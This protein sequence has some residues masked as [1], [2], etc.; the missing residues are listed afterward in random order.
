MSARKILLHGGG[1]FSVKEQSIKDALRG[2]SSLL[3]IP[4]ARPGGSAC[5]EVTEDVR[6]GFGNAGLTIKINGIE[7]YRNPRKAVEDA[8]AVFVGGGN[9]FVLLKSLYDERL[10]EIMRAGVKEGMPY[11]GASAGANVAGQTIKTTNDMP[12]VYPPSFNAIGL[13]PFVINPHFP[14]AN[15]SGSGE[16][17]EDRIREYLAFNGGFVVGLQEESILY[18]TGDKVSLT[19]KG[20]ATVFSMGEKAKDYEIGASL[21]FLLG[22]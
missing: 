13:V 12:I 10:I 18:I 11:L 7:E 3:F 15:Q 16:T 22:A 17:R 14:A 1:V 6:E 19:G 8:E 20:G 21:K 9:T 2:S 4:Y 5:A